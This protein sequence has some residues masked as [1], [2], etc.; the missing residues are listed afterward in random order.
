MWN[1]VTACEKYAEKMREKIQLPFYNYFFKC[2]TMYRFCSPWHGYICEMIWPCQ[3]WHIPP[4]LAHIRIGLHTLSPP[5]F[6]DN[7]VAATLPALTLQPPPT[8]ILPDGWLHTILL[9]AYCL[10][11]RIPF[12]WPHTI[13]LTAYRLADLLPVGW[14]H[15]I[16]LNANRLA[17]R[18]PFGWPN[19]VWLTAYHVPSHLLT[20][21]SPCYTTT[22]YR[23]M[24]LSRI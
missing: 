21:W 19:I 17:D 8:L 13:W 24:V 18:I 22:T 14:P 4:I 20:T 16:W 23:P 1:I 3:V 10:A 5:F 6:H 15:T 11:D 9:T 2:V 12:S 7:S